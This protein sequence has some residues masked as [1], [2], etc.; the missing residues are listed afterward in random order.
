M[1]ASRRR[2]ASAARA[3]RPETGMSRVASG[4]SIAPGSQGVFNFSSS[5]IGRLALDVE[6][7]AKMKTA[8]CLGTSARRLHS[9]GGLAGRDE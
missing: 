6:L 4:C 1:W 3:A 2:P 9:G 5:M 7:R 8:E